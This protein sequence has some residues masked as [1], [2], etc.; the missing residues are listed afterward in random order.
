MKVFDRAQN[1][2]FSEEV[3]GDFFIRMAYSYALGQKV[4]SNPIV[5]KGFSRLIGI[6]QDLPFSKRIIPEFIERYKIVMSDYGEDISAYRTFND[7]FIRPFLEGA[8]SFPSDPKD[9]GAP[10]E[11]RLSVFPVNG[12][13]TR[14]TIKGKN[15]SVAELVSS[16]EMAQSF[17]WGHAM[18]FRLAPVD[19]HRF[20]F[21][22][23]GIPNQAFKLGNRLHSVNPLAQ[24][25]IPELFLWNERQV[26]FFQSE[27]FGPLL[28]IEVGAMGV[29]K[30]SQTFEANV[31]V[32]RG[33][34]K[35]YFSFGGSTVIVLSQKAYFQPDLDIL[36]R[37]ESGLESLVRLGEK[38]G[39]SL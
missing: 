38:V 4:V 20:H 31:S 5:Q 28:I 27:H 6:W 30:I 11:G 15:L 12:A 16:D 35:G 2:V 7:F 34:E 1:R 9:F 33:Q 17:A 22:D 13:Q 10:A 24:R 3:Y 14:L 19:Y 23:S 26:T 8:R 37:T 25:A 21:P 36:D 32:Q 18:V 29:G 39:R